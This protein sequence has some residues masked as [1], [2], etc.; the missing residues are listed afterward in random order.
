MGITLPALIMIVLLPAALAY[1]AASDFVAMSISNRLTVGLTLGFFVAA[2]VLGLS[3][4][5]VAWHLGAGLMVLFVT[6]ALFAAGWIGG[7]DAKLAAA[8]ALWL[9]FGQLLPYLVIA[10]FLGGLLTYA[11]LFYRDQP[12]P[13]SV[14]RLDFARRLHAAKEGVPYGI[15]LAAAALLVLPETSIWQIAFAP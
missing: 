13:E 5:Q 10:G 2:A 4:S 12:L 3:W 11:I 7:G 8:T 6:F 9:G 14:K 1:A 15:A